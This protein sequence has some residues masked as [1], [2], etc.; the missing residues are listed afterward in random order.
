VDKAGER[1]L[2]YSYN[3]AQL[4]RIAVP[5]LA[6]Q[7]CSCM[8]ITTDLRDACIYILSR[9]VVE[10]I[11]LSSMSSIKV[12]YPSSSEINLHSTFAMAS[13]WAGDL[14][15]F[16][17][18]CHPQGTKITEYCIPCMLAALFTPRSSQR[19]YSGKRSVMPALFAGH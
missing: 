1:L 17:S 8:E 10:R 4:H 6:L 13:A 7:A 9:A 11:R 12:S 5:A 3:P 14:F 16:C 18:L 19:F 15:R 2:S